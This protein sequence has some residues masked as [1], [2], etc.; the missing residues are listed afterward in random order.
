[1]NAQTWKGKTYSLSIRVGD[2]EIA[3][4]S[5]GARSGRLASRLM[6]NIERK[7]EQEGGR[8]EDK[9]GEGD[10]SEIFDLIVS[11]RGRP[12]AHTRPHP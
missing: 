9:S 4:P 12:Q 10:R 1:M 5:L 3:P 6:Y 11:D 7:E 2:I 8:K